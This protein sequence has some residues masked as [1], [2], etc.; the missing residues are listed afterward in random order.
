MSL[1]LAGLARQARVDEIVRER[2]PWVRSLWVSNYR[3][4]VYAA[5]AGYRPDTS[6]LTELAFGQ[7]ASPLRRA[8]M[9]G[10]HDGLDSLSLKENPNDAR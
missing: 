8:Y 3:T 7:N 10:Y 5:L 9:C 6:Y 4:G 2:C 1:F